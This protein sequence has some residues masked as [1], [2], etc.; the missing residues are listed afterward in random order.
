MPLR[1]ANRFAANVATSLPIALTPNADPP[2]THLAT[3]IQEAWALLQEH[4]R[5]IDFDAL[6]QYDPQAEEEHDKPRSND[7]ARN[8]G[9]PHATMEVAQAEGASPAPPTDEGK[10]R[11]VVFELLLRFPCRTRTFRRLRALAGRPNRWVFQVSF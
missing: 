1:P 10:V 8:V 3:F 9:A 6:S 11:C 7:E 2:C 4:Y 5:T